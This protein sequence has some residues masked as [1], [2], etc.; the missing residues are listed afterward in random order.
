MHPAGRT[1]KGVPTRDWSVLR[2][3]P[4]SG[5]ETARGRLAEALRGRSRNDRRRV[6][7]AHH[8]PQLFEGGPATISRCRGPDTVAACR[9]GQPHCWL[10]KTCRGGDVAE[11]DEELSP[12][13]SRP[14]AE[15]G[16]EAVTSVAAAHAP[17]HC[18]IGSPQ[19]PFEHPESGRIGGGDDPR[20]LEQVGGDPR[21]EPPFL[22]HRGACLEGVAPAG[23]SRGH[24][25][26]HVAGPG[27]G[28]GHG[29]VRLRPGPNS[30]PES[31]PGVRR[32]LRPVA[33]LF[34]EACEPFL[35]DNRL[36]L[37]GAARG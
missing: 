24:D 6:R 25:V 4:T 13:R 15:T 23:R 32:L 1:P 18:R 35:T 34:D 37:L 16:Q 27:A 17:H 5:A 10:T 28:K 22:E 31:T 36:E 26:D 9:V 21:P 2:F 7:P 3:P 19:R 29:E 14:A 11:P 20:T 30:T 8:P 12:D 33:E